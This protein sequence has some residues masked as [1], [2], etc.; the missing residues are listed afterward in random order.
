MRP[1]ASHPQARCQTLSCPPQLGS[2]TWPTMLTTAL[3][4]PRAA[5]LLGNVGQTFD[6]LQVRLQI[7]SHL[8]RLRAFKLFH[9]LLM[10]GSTLCAGWLGTLH[11]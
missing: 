9:V 7:Q 3:A 6:H 1:P 10:A 5:S 8:A 2:S 11:L 4:G